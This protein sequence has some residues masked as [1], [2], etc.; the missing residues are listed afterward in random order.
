MNNPRKLALASLVKAE[1]SSTYSNIEVNTVISRSKLSKVDV[2]LYTALY[3]GVTEKI[4]TLDYLISK[5]SSSHIME[6]DIETKNALRIGFYQLLFMDKIPDY[7]AVSETVN[8][9]PRRSKGFVNACLRSFIRDDKELVLPSDKWQAVSVKASIPL[10]IINIFR[11][12]YGDDEA[13]KIAL[14]LSK[15]RKGVTIRINSMKIDPRELRKSLKNRA[16][17]YTPVGFSEELL[18]INAPISDF[19]DLI[20]KGLCFVQDTAS[21]ACTKIVGANGGELILDACACPGGK[22]FSCAIDMKNTGKIVACD[23]HKNKLPLV[24]NGA[25]RLGITIVEAY[26]QDAKVLREDFVEKFDKVL[27][28]A[29]CSGLGIISKKPDIKYKPSE[30]IYNLPEVQLAI[31]KNCANYVRLGG[32]LIYSTCTLNKAEN[33]RVVKRFLEANDCF[34]MLDFDLGDIKSSDGMFTFMPHKLEADG[35]FVAKMKRIK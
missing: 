17:P 9:C 31:L 24:T 29:P 2:A 21:F 6:L 23:L 11:E 14:A 10:A 27:C 18:V 26:E 28:D 13:E 32:E 8:I 4:I 34:E 33:E 7:S 35:F 19:V 12:S 5:Y 16:I 22:T 1:L 15:Q 20:D 3:L 30:Q 25:S